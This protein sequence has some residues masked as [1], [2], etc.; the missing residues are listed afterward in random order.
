MYKIQM[1]RGNGWEPHNAL[2]CSYS[3]H[4]ASELVKG[5]NMIAKRPGSA[6]YGMRF[7]KVKVD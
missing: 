2:R 3:K 1:N 6:F 5:Y 7:R 4:D